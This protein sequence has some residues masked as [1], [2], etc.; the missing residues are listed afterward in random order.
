[1]PGVATLLKL[2]RGPAKAAG[3]AELQGFLERGFAAFGQL[4]DVRG[5]IAEIEAGRARRGPAP[6]RPATPIRSAAGWPERAG[7]AGRR[8]QLKRSSQHAADLG[9]D[10]ALQRRQQEAQLRGHVQLVRLQCDVAVDAAAGEVQGVAVPLAG[11]AEAIGQLVGDFLD[12]LARLARV[13][14]NANGGCRCSACPGSPCWPMRPLL[15]GRCP[16]ASKRAWVAAY[17]PDLHARLRPRE[18]PETSIPQP[19][20]WPTSC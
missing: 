5:F 14:A 4:G 3:L 16:A 19:R 11:H 9:L 15:C 6:V 7:R 13:R 2:S 20:T 1:M 17:V 8:G 10:R 12:G 18:C